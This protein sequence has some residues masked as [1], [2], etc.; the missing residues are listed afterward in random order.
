[1]YALIIKGID[2]YFIKNE[3]ADLSTAKLH[4]AME[5]RKSEVR[6]YSIFNGEEIIEEKNKPF[7]PISSSEAAAT[8]GAISTPKK[9]AT[10]AENGKKGGRPKKPV[11]DK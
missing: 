3:Y 1:M 9:A 7:G 11:A 4:A 8:L 5:Y 10:S 2:N 6:H